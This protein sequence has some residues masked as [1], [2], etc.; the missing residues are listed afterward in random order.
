MVCMDLLE[1][2]DRREFAVAE[3]ACPACAGP[4]PAPKPAKPTRQRCPVAGCEQ[5]CWVAPDRYGVPNWGGCRHVSSIVSIDGGPFVIE[6][7]DK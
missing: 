4:P 5:L 7:A 2:L 6:F 1:E 3:K